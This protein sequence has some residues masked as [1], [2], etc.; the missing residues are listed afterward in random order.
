M[1]RATAFFLFGIVALGSLSFMPKPKDKRVRV[2][3]HTNLGD[4][5]V[6]LYDETPLHRDNFIKL[7]KAGTYD[8]TLFHRVISEFMIQGG[9]PDSKKAQP[10]VMLG[11]GNVGYTVPAEFNPKLF[12]KRGVL[13]AARMSDEVNPK[14]ESSGCQFYIVQ[15]K[16]YNDS[17]LKTV[18]DRIN[19]P[20]KQQIFMDLINRPENASL[21]AAFMRNQVNGN[22]DSL[23]ILS[24][25]VNPMIDAEFAKAPHH[26]FTPEQI[27]AYKTVGGVPHLDG[28]YTVFGEV[29]SGFE[30][31]DKIAATPRNQFDRPNTDI[32]MTMKIVKK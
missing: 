22:G 21:R 11:N 7:V 13:A 27:E 3:I 20:I 1:T 24:K 9:D 23:Q 16:V 14:K 10:G 12:H 29:I 28:N 5:K 25:Q 4:I 18:D 32:R 8:S 17:T 6:V 2:L 30:V 26:T 15:G 19:T 31:I